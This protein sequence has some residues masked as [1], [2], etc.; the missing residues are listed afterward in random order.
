MII[1]PSSHFVV[2]QPVYNFSLCVANLPVTLGG[3][4]QT[5][6]HSVKQALTR[7]NKS[8]ELELEMDDLD[9]NVDSTRIEQIIKAQVQLGDQ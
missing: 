7:S 6:S 3:L 8:C 2:R 1:N 4:V 5:S 9:L